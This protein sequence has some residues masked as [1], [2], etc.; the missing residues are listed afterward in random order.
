MDNALLQG[1]VAAFSVMNLLF[2][3]IGCLLGT[4]VGVLPGLGPASAMAILLPIT[5]HMPPEGAIIIMAGRCMAV[6]PRPF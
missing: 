5:M 4:L 3:F 1:L 2:A 6:R